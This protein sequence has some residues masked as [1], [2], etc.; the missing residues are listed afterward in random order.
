MDDSIPMGESPQ[1]APAQVAPVGLTQ[2]EVNK[3]V[4]EARVSGREAAL[5]EAQANQAAPMT[6]EEMAAQMRE[7]AAQVQFEQTQKFHVQQML[8]KLANKVQ[9]GKEKY[10]DFEEKLTELQLHTMPGLA[11]ELAEMADEDV[12]YDIVNNPY[13]AMS[14]DAAIKNGT[15]HIARKELQKLVKSV[16]DNQKAASQTAEL[17]E[18]LSKVKPSAITGDTAKNSVADFRKADW[19]RR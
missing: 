13:K 15:P 3:L 5:R 8:G 18:P 11:G 16:K 10:P 17:N 19:A 9:L 12:I 14:L 2:A 1:V 6:R 4:G 7:V